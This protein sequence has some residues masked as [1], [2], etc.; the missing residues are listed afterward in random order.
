MHGRQQPNPIRKYLR[1]Y[2]CREVSRGARAV[3]EGWKAATANLDIKTT[4]LSRGRGEKMKGGQRAE[5]DRE[6]EREL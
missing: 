1:R 3:A 4:G 6:R 5:E 2:A